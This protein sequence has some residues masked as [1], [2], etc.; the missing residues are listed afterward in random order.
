MEKEKAGKA[1]IGERRNVAG[2]DSEFQDTLQEDQGDVYGRG[3]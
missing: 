3:G 2:G 1:A